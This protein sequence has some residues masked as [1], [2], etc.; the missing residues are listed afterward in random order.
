MSYKSY[1]KIRGKLLG[2]S[3]CGAQIPEKVTGN[4]QNSLV[5]L[6]HL[7]LYFLKK[8]GAKCGNS[9]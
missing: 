9:L 7:A 8:Y 3:L 1:P 2:G 4:I 5:S 6:L